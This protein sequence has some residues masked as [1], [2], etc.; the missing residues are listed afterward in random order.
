MHLQERS[1]KCRALIAAYRSL[2]KMSWLVGNA[3][4]SDV[5]KS[6]NLSM[7]PVTTNY[8]TVSSC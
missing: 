3:V 2:P 8:R 1:E 7:L 5:S 6:L 4:A